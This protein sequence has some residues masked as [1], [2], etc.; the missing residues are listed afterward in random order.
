MTDEPIMLPG[1][2]HSASDQATRA[3]WMVGL[4]CAVLLVM[5]A[6]SMV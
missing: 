3:V 6:W 5:L 1:Q 2:G 4:A